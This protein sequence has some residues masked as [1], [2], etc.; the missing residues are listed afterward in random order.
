MGRLDRPVDPPY[1]R[2]VLL[3][4]QEVARRI[5]ARPGQSSFSALSVRMQLLA[6]CGS[7]CPMPPRCFQPPPKV[8]SEVIS[9]DP[10]TA[11][12]RPPQVVAKQLERL[13]RLAFGSRRKM[14]RNTL[15]SA[16]PAVGLEAW[17]GDA[18]ITPQ[19]RPRT[20]H[21]AVGS[22]GRCS[23]TGSVSS[24]SLRAPAKINLHLEVL[25]LKND[26]FHELSMVMQTLD[27][28]D[29][30]TVKSAPAGQVSLRCSDPP[31][32]RWMA[33]I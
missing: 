19:Q 26:G 32:C 12:Q 17:L 33:A 29:E 5:S 3:V 22:V 24:L 30:L 6:D 20:L 10:K 14:V 9:I 25:G 16:A 27:L 28:A 21:P 11:D 18:G 8:Q 7:V 31:S 23:A 15:A 13:L 2:L 1:H 4:Q